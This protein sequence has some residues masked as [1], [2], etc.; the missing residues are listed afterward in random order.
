MTHRWGFALV[1]ACLA[2]CG[3]HRVSAARMGAVYTAKKAPCGLRFE[4]LNHQEASAKFDMIGL[5]TVTDMPSSALT[6]EVKRD[7]EREACGLGA[8]AVTLNAGVGNVLQFAAW[9]AK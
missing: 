7:V 4:N 1:L 3:G 9:H 2:G 6:D 5:V 8:D